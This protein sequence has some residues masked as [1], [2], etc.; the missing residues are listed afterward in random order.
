[1]LKSSPVKHF[2][3]DPWRS[4]NNFH[5]RSLKL[6]RHYTS[7]VNPAPILIFGNQKSGTSAITALLGEATRSSYTIDVYCHYLG[8]EKEM[9]QGK[10][11]TRKLLEI[12]RYHFSKVIIKDPGFIFFYEELNSHFPESKKVFIYRDPRQNIRSILNRLNLPGHFHDLDQGSWEKLEA[13]FPG[14]YLVLEGSLAGHKGKTYIETLALRWRRVMETYFNNKI[15]FV[16]IRYESFLSDKIGM[17][18]HLAE[19]LGLEVKENISPL[20]DLQ[21]QPKGNKNISLEAFFG[22]KNLRIIEEI[23][24]KIMIDVGYDL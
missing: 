22:S 24:G 8:L 1:M 21:F 19:L 23:C 10:I 14:W 18:A 13:K 6:W 12:V 7:S 9:L 4:A 3:E 15:D 5:C 16:P 20:K 11:E 17:I 2:F